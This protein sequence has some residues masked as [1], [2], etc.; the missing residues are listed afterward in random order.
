[1]PKGGR[2]GIGKRLAMAGE[3]RPSTFLLAPQKGRNFVLK[4]KSCF[5]AA[6]FLFLGTFVPMA[7]LA[8]TRFPIKRRPESAEVCVMHQRKQ[9]LNIM[10]AKLG[11]S[12]CAWWYI[13]P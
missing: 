7:Q 1:M 8:W 3:K 5:F 10:V 2:P 9:D 6:P 13:I 12:H 4:A 11:M